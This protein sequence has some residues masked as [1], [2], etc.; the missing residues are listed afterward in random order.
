MN[1]RKSAVVSRQFEVATLQTAVDVDSVSPRGC[2]VG[3]EHG[4][5]A[6]GKLGRFEAGTGA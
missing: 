2:G 4:Q 6:L 3:V 5:D 1:K